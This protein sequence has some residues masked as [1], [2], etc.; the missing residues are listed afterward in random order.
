MQASRTSASRLSPSRTANKI[1]QNMVAAQW[2]KQHASKERYRKG[3]SRVKKSCARL[4]DGR[5]SD[6]ASTFDMH[7]LRVFVPI[8]S[9]MLGC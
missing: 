2:L 1:C 7:D 9:G 6:S 4:A 3:G 8:P 5:G